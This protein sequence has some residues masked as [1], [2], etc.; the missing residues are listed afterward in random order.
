[1]KTGTLIRKENSWWV[2]T[3]ETKDGDDVIFKDYPLSLTSS[4]MAGFSLKEGKKV[5]FNIEREVYTDL[6]EEIIEWAILETEINRI[7]II[8][9]NQKDMEIGR[10]FS[11]R[12]N[13]ELS[14]QDGGKTL[15]VFI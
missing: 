2:R 3:T 6:G 12:G 11:F 13:M 8:N 7:E 10:I 15:K 14:L 4:Y 1:M 5:N 9:H